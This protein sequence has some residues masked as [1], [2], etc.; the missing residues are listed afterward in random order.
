MA[1]AVHNVGVGPN[2]PLGLGHHIHVLHLPG[3]GEGGQE[4]CRHLADV[5]IEVVCLAVAGL[6]VRDVGGLPGALHLEAGDQTHEAGVL[7]GQ[8]RQS[9]QAAQHS[10]HSVVINVIKSPHLQ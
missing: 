2:H 4:T 8:I 10:G 3:V 5:P 9:G 6:C 7:L 1:Q